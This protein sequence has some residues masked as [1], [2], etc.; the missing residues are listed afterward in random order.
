MSTP[1]TIS[2]ED[3]I[4][5]IKLSC[6]MRSVV[7]TI[8]THK[9]MTEAAQ[10]AGIQVSEE[11]L[12][13]EGDRLRFAK[14]LVKAQDTWEWL[15]KNH[16]SLDDFKALIHNNILANKL[17]HHLFA[18]KVEQFFYEHQLNYFAAVTYEVILNDRDLA[19]ELFYSLQEGEITFQEIAREYIQIPELRRA[20][21]YQGVRR[22]TDFRPEIAAAVFA[23]NPP[24]ILK[25][26]TTS[27]GVYFI[28]VE[29][30]IQPILDEQLRANIQ[31]E[32]FSIWLKQQIEAM[33]ITTHFH[34]DTS[35]QASEKTA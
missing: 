10:Q 2:C 1:L 12:Q 9:I 21:G 3:I 24:E 17:A 15:T 26:I 30:I 18:D 28:W 32:L 5:S 4:R 11:E 14:K 31:Q 8:A 13:Q 35:F 22:R 20:V 6:Q 29:E 33:E 23:A 34:S 25:P 27:K 16:L 7:E 19:L